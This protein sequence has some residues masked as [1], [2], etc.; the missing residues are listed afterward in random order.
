MDAFL[1]DAELNRAVRG[2]TGADAA[3]ARALL[4]EL[5]RFLRLAA[6]HRDARLSP[7]PAVDAAWHQL[8]LLPVLYYRVC[9][10]AAGGGGEAAPA[11]T[12]ADVLVPHST[13]GALDPAPARR[14]R[15]EAALAAYTAEYL[16]PPPEAV[17]P[18]DYAAPPPVADGAAADDGDVVVAPPAKRG[19]AEPGGAEP[20]T[21][22]VKVVADDWNRTFSITVRPDMR[23]SL[24]FRCIYKQ[25]GAPAGTLKII[26]DGSAVRAEDTAESLGLEEGD[27]IEVQQEKYGC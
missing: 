24:L 9:E 13:A 25:L 3:V 23:M 6:R 15:Y 10:A 27:L 2:A 16:T 12:G 17:W 11:R 18:R 26:F 7:S 1:D 21:I 22:N 19:R 14:A 4:V 20:G 5:F 8:L